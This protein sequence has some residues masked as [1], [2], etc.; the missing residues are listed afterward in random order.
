MHGK[1]LNNIQ[2]LLIVAA[3]CFVS[4]SRAA[5]ED[6]SAKESSDP[7]PPCEIDS[8]EPCPEGEGE[9]EELERGFDPCLINSSLPACKP[10]AEGG[11]SAAAE[12]APARTRD[13]DDSG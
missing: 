8:G 7:Q 12:K 3:L 6:S 10:E 2:A 9:Q 11:D 13:S 1:S 5:S 4:L